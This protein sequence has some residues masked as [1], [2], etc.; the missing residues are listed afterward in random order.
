MVDA[1]LN[2]APNDF[3]RDDYRAVDLVACNECEGEI[4][5]VY[6][7]GESYDFISLYGQLED[8]TYDVL[9][10]FDV[11]QKHHHVIAKAQELSE[12]LELP[13]NDRVPS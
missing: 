13:L 10:D 12:A 2:C 9:H 5:N 8:G 1:V 3:N 4:T 7:S 6:G 11:G